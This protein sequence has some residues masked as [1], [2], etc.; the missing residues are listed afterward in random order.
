MAIEPR[1]INKETTK[2]NDSGSTY[3]MNHL[4]NDSAPL[5]VLCQLPLIT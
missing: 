4:V 3:L 1:N 5:E 2:I